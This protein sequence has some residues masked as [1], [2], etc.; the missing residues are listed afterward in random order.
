MRADHHVNENRF[1]PNGT[2]DAKAV[3]LPGNAYQMSLFLVVRLRRQNSMFKEITIRMQ[4]VMKYNAVLAAKIEMRLELREKGI[5][6]LD[7]I[8][9]R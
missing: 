8:E 5:K 3:F 2:A 7:A 4:I 1:R 6:Q 9:L